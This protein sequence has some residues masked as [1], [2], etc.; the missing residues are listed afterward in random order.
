MKITHIIV[1]LGDGGAESTLYKLISGDK[2]NQHTVISLTNYGRYGEHLLK[3]KIPLITLNFK[4]NRLNLSKIYK[5]IKVIKKYK[6]DVIQSWMYHSD[7][8]TCLIKLFFPSIKVVWGIRNSVYRAKESYVRYSISKICSYFSYIVPEAIISCSY[9]AMN[10][11]I[12]LGYSK[13]KFRVVPN[14]VNL[15]KFFPKNIPEFKNNLRE[16]YSFDIKKI[17]IG[18]VARYDKQKGLNILIK[19][20][21]ILQIKDIEFNCFLVGTNMNHDNKNL[22]SMI[23][24]YNLNSKIFLLG[25][26]NDIDNIYNFL[27]LSI[28][29]STSGEGFPNVLIESMACGTPCV[30]TNVGD[31]KFIVDNTGWIAEPG[32]YKILASLIE[33]AI[34]EFNQKEWSQRKADCR[35][36]I[37]ANFDLGKMIENFNNVWSKI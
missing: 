22:V 1:G 6:P 37:K 26:K 18:M 3:F 19:A 32:D 2:K 16:N 35:N 27:D 29:S 14:G 10:E 9:Q 13:K 20:L 24:E 33:K 21:N 12:K 25:Q 30:T 7:I 23:N 4:K 36:R 34:E 5:L 17:S 31:S 28:L 8:I 15:D 11:H